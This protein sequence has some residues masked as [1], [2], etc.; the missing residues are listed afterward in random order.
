V[1]LLARA[2]VAAEARV[3]LE[4]GSSLTTSVGALWAPPQAIEHGEGRVEVSLAALMVA[5]CLDVLGEPR[6]VALSAC[7][8][9][10]AGQLRGAGRGY[11]A[12][13]DSVG[14]PWLALGA[15]VR[16]Q[17]A[18]SGPLGWNA[19]LTG[20]TPILRERFAVEGVSGTAFEP[21][22]VALVAGVGLGLSIW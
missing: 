16:T 2:G 19:G 7:A 3:E 17:G 11:S 20:W 5:A 1:G 9:Q 14:R 22:P 12:Y 18:I 21:P 13:T 8:A 10:A 6:T 4:I 15:A